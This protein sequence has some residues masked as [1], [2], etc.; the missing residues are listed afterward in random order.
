MK[1]ITLKQPWASLVSNGYKLYEFRS[2]KLKYR[3][4]IIIHAGKA[5]DKDAME[6]V[7]DLN[8]DFPSMKLLAI[9]SLDDCIELNDEINKKICSE[10]PLIYGN[11]NR[12]GYAWKLSNVRKITIDKTIPG[13]Q[14]IWNYDLEE[15][16]E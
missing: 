8:L 13:K 14:G 10:N 7:K 4:D 15:K 5:V 2:W 9:V 1:V 6:K 16:Q 11:K 3:G 12:T